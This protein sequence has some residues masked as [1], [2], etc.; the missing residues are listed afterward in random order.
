LEVSELVRVS[1]GQIPQLSH[2]PLFNCLLVS[3]AKA[4]KD[5]VFMNFCS[6]LSRSIPFDS[7]LSVKLLIVLRVFL[8]RRAIL[9]LFTSRIETAV[10]ST[11]LIVSACNI[12]ASLLNNKS[13]LA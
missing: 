4:E 13:L 2:S 8:L 7:P 9:D 6:N 3:Q 1:K 5:Y 11:K 12:P 10:K